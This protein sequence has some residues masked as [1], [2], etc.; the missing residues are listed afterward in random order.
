[1]DSKTIYT[2]LQN[3]ERVTRDLNFLGVFPLDMIPV[4]ALLQYPCCLVVN[5]KPKDNPGEHWV[6][7]VKTEENRGIYFDSF[8]YPPSNLPE[9]GLVLDSC[10]EWTY[11]ESRLQSVIST[12]CGQYCIFF[13]TH[14][15]R[16][17]SMDHITSLINDAGDQFANDALVFNYIRNKYDIASLQKLPIIDFPF[18]FQQISRSLS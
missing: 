10:D 1:M 11:N 2:V 5:T 15:A 16:G 4:T 14:F 12:V 9:I 6:C 3:D 7:I 18:V 13:L 8:G 17:Y